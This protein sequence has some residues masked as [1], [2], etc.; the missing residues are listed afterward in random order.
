MK[1]NIQLLIVFALVLAVV[2]LS[3]SDSAWAGK[4]F[5]EKPNT[6]E[7]QNPTTLEPGPPSISITETGEYNVGGICNMDIVYEENS[8]LSSD[9]DIDVPTD[10]STEIP[11]GYLGDL[12]L[13]GCHVVHY[14]DNEIIREIDVD[15]GSSRVCFAERPGVELTIYYYLEEPFTTSPIWIELETT[16]KDGL[17]CAQAVYS[18][19]YAPGSDV[20]D[21]VF[22]PAETTTVYYPGYEVG[23]VVVPPSSVTFTESGTY[24]AGGICSFRVLYYEPYQTNEIHVADALRYDFDPVAGYD[25]SIHDFFPEGEGLL[26]MPGCHVLHYNRGEIAHWEKYVDQ[27]DWEICFAAQPGKEMTIYSYLGDLEDQEDA[28]IPL[29]TTVED[30]E[31]CAPAFFTGVYVPTGK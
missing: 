14:K 17:A 4:L 21:P 2:G 30:G 22:E 13:P 26:Y 27:G 15:D 18:G 3:K 5:Q 10:L 6:H 8:G 20:D 19:E 28:W 12:Y 1:K 31:A 24:S 23:S 29:E 16:H 11:F 7:V 9:V 25:Y